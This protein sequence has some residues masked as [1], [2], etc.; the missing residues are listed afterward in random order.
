VDQV[1]DDDLHTECLALRH[2]FRWAGARVRGRHADASPQC[3][4]EAA[5]RGERVVE[6]ET[7]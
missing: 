4:K 7:D 6:Q 5:D 1:R 2:E 3:A